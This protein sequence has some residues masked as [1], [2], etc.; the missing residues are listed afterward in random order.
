M[1]HKRVTLGEVLAP[2]KKALISG[3]FGSDIGKKFFVAKGVPVIRGNNLSLDIRKFI[4]DGF[5]FLTKEKADELGAYAVHNDLLFTAAGTIGQVGIIPFDA[6]YPEYIISNKQIRARLNPD[7][8][9][10]SFAYY[11]FSSPWIAKEI[12]NKN[13]GST[14]PLINLTVLRGLGISLPNLI[15]QQKIAAVLTAL[16][17]KIELNNKT[18]AELEAMAKT[19]YDYWFVQFDFP[20]GNGKPYKL[21]GGKMVYNAT[22]KRE[23]PEGWVVKSLGETCSTSL[24]GTPSTKVKEYWE[25]E[26]NWINSGEVANFPMVKSDATISQAAIRNSATKILK[27]GSV[28]ISITRHLRPNILGIDACVNQSVVGIEEDEAFKKSFLYPF[29]TNEIPRLMTL[30]TGAQQPHIN[31]ETVDSCFITQPS[32]NI[33]EKYYSISE[34]Y[35][36][37]IISNA[38]Q[39]QELSSLRDWLLPML[40]NGQ[41]SVG[42]VYEMVEEVLSVAAEGE[43]PYKKIKK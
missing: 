3:P 41:V 15:A 11:W 8:I 16:D 26:I 42:K 36:D 21:S 24:G 1:M 20:D 28:L 35:F 25:G 39:N 43:T 12:L 33:L 6:K 29:I 5:V 18:N 2:E 23:I 10:F 40:M 13:T 14:V 19:L 4:D 27:K 31:K 34:K 17:D 37:N 32:E 30:R 22:L 9:D 7:I 38:K